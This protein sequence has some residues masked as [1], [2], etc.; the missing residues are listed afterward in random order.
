MRD[1]G[2]PLFYSVFTRLDVTYMGHYV[3]LRCHQD[4]YMSHMLNRKNSNMALFNRIKSDFSDFYL[5]IIP[6]GMFMVSIAYAGESINTYTN[7]RWENLFEIFQIFF[8]VTIILVGIPASIYNVILE[9]RKKKAGVQSGE[10]GFV[11]SIY[12]ATAARSFSFVFIL[13][14]IT[15][16][17]GPRIFPAQQAAF[18]LEAVISASLMF[19][20]VA[21]WVEMAKSGDADG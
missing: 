6:F 9:I 10:T 5:N 15:E 4:A 16:Q 11:Q 21:F 12:N 8:A 1:R 7:D 13:L 14:L 19:F 18:F 3:T 2:Q 20:A 17:L